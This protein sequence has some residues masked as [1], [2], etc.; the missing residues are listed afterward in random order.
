[1]GT[2]QRF[3]GDRGSLVRPAAPA[4]AQSDELEEL[5]ESEVLELE[6]ESLLELELELE[7]EAESELEAEELDD[8]F[9]EP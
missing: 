8:G 5:E 3:G 9:E 4:N 2:S 1:M 7:L 6:E